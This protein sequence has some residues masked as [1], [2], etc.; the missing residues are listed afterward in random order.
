LSKLGVGVVEIS[1]D[2]SSRTQS[3]KAAIQ[4]CFLP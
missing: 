3:A 4:K 1:G 2:F